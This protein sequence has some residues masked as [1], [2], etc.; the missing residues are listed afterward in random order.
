MCCLKTPVL[1]KAKCMIYY[2]F[3]EDIFSVLFVA[4]CIY[5]TMSSIH[6]AA[7]EKITL[8]RDEEWLRTTDI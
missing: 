3:T 1:R 6:A 4:Y 8:S 2:Y 7:G 5:I